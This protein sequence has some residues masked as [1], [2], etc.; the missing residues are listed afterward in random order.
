MIIRI[1]AFIISTF[2][3]QSVS[4]AQTFSDSAQKRLAYDIVVTFSNYGAR[5]NNCGESSYLYLLMATDAIVENTD[6]DK[7]QVIDVLNNGAQLERERTGP[8]CNSAML[9]T[10]KSIF[11]NSLNGFASEKELLRQPH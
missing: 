7:A 4:Q 2:L 9:A 5:L 10:F 3:L 6:F 8:A 1:S 11:A